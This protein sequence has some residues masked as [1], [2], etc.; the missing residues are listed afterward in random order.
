MTMTMAIK[1]GPPPKA[2]PDPSEGGEKADPEGGERK[3]HP[4]EGR[5]TTL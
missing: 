3:P 5:S 2:S 1:E 4:K